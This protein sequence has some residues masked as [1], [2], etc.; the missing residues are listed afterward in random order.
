ME[1]HAESVHNR[2]KK[3]TCFEKKVSFL[4]ESGEQF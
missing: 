1:I 4:N 2:I 3:E